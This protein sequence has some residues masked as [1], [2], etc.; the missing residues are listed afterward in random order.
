MSIVRVNFLP[1]FHLGDDAVLL[2]LDG[3]GVDEVKAAVVE[4]RN[5]RS[6]RLLHDGVVHEFH[7]KPGAA[8]VELSPALVVWRLDD[9]KASEIVDDLV[10]LSAGGNGNTAG[11]FYVDMTS[12]AETLVISRDEYTDVVYPWMS[13]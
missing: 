3:R 4:A 2:T 11:H 8:T 13:P 9:A 6:S 10:S 7:I 5:N 1:E 12:P